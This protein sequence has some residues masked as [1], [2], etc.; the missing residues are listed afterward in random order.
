MKFRRKYKIAA[1]NLAFGKIDHAYARQ[2][3]NF[4]KEKW[5]KSTISVK[6]DSNKRRSKKQKKIKS[7]HLPDLS[8]VMA[9]M[10]NKISYPNYSTPSRRHTLQ[11]RSKISGHM[12]TNLA[13]G[14]Q[15]R[16]Q[17]L[18]KYSSIQY[19]K[20]RLSDYHLSLDQFDRIDL[21]AKI[22]F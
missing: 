17:L 2:E 16:R 22:K 1:K 14:M 5:K 9:S 10:Y 19:C 11:Y 6:K 18:K 15:H 7:D 20:N 12:T 8:E 13:Y 21:P 3:V 4:S